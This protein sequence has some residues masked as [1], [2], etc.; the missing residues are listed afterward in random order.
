M[1]C[2]TETVQVLR[3]AGHK[4][5]PQRLSI[6]AALRHT[7]GHLTALEVHRQVRVEHPYVD[8][9]TV[10]RTLA[11]LR[12]LGLVSETAMAGGDHFYEWLQANDH[13]HH[14]LCRR[15]G[16]TELLD[17]HHLE[18]LGA[19]VLDDHGF[20]LDLNHIALSGLCHDC[21]AAE[22]AESPAPGGS[23]GD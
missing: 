4:L 11:V 9:S 7:S 10:Y 5:T 22:P 17:H 23:H 15:C 19:E 2:E 16:G 13:H 6:V 3:R 18:N 20:R 21:L 12:E 1:S 14:L 8:L